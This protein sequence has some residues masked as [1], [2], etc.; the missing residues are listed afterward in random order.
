ME[1]NRKFTETKKQSIRNKKGSEVKDN[2]KLLL[3]SAYR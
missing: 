1:L 2:A 3:P